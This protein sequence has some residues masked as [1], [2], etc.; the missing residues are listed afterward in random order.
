MLFRS[1]TPPAHVEPEISAKYGDYV[2]NTLAGCPACHTA[3][4]LKTGEYL[5]PFFSGGLAFRAHQH[6]GYM[7]VSPNLTPDPETGRLAGWTEDAFVQRFRA[8]L[9]LADSPMPWANLTH[10]TDTDLRALY[11]YLRSLAPVRRDNGPTMQKEH[12]SVAG[13]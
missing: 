7:Y 4:N 12:G 3:R 2:A 1:A 10:M 6:P 13:D 5:S 9:L 11:R 8:G